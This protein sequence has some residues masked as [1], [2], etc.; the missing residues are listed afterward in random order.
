MAIRQHVGVFYT[1]MWDEWKYGYLRTRTGQV[2]YKKRKSNVVRPPVS[3]DGTSR[4][5]KLA[6]IAIVLAACTVQRSSGIDP[7]GSIERR[8]ATAGMADEAIGE[9]FRVISTEKSSKKD[10]DLLVKYIKEEIMRT[11]QSIKTPSGSIEAAARR[12]QKLVTEL[13]AA[14]TTAIYKSKSTEEAKVNFGRFQNTVQSI[15]DFI[16]NGQFVI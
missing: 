8:A 14:Y 2:V 3:T 16:K 7:R 6:A 1:R 9:I 15:V 4:M 5:A 10:D 12:A 13:T 11:A